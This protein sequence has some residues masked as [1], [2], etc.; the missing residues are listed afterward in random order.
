MIALKKFPHLTT[1][2]KTARKQSGKV[3]KQTKR[4]TKWLACHIA[5]SIDCTGPE[6]RGKQQQW[7]SFQA[8]GFPRR[9]RGQTAS[10]QVW[11]NEAPVGVGGPDPGDGHPS[12][13]P[14]RSGMLEASRGDWL[15]RYDH[16]GP[17]STQA[18]LPARHGRATLC[19]FQATLRCSRTTT[20]QWG[21]GHCVQWVEAATC[22]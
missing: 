15:W 10:A 1:I 4:Q 11:S 8:A 5:T 2:P 12:L 6:G 22:I 21:M 20:N 16:L 7:W 9:L 18:Y 14:P 13:L 19:L 17:S 3:A